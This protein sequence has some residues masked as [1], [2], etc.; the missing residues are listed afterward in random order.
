MEELFVKKI[1]E[2]LNNQG[3]RIDSTIK[4]DSENDAEDFLVHPESCIGIH[5]MTYDSNTK[6]LNYELG[7]VGVTAARPDTQTEK[8]LQAYFHRVANNVE[9]P[10]KGVEII[11][12]AAKTMHSRLKERLTFSVNLLNEA[13]D[14]LHNSLI[15][16][17]YGT[18]APDFGRPEKID[19]HKISQEE[20]NLILKGLRST[21]LWSTVEFSGT[22]DNN[23]Y[24]YQGIA[25]LGISTIDN[26]AKLY[27]GMTVED[28]D[29]SSTGD[30]DNEVSEPLEK[31]L[32][33]AGVWVNWASDEMYGV[34][35][36]AVERASE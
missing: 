21:V 29:Y 2:L 12:A 31:D 33:D 17:P 18:I 10:L 5:I 27:C 32:L 1:I 6:A 13:I 15:H 34:A 8:E 22:T 14:M 11:I 9:T 35:T 7:I 26:I 23:A 25:E 19:V 3:W 30:K 24:D 36:D 20:L 4:A 28:R 16:N